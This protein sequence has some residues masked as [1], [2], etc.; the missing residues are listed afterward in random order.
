MYD[1]GDGGVGLDIAQTAENEDRKT[2]RRGGTR[3]HVVLPVSTRRSCPC[4]AAA[5]RGTR[6]RVRVRG[7]RREA[8]SAKREVQGRVVVLDWACEL[9]QRSQGMYHLRR[10]LRRL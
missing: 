6:S 10:L 8:R 4:P 2:G 5:V 1:A 9:D 7:A 3:T